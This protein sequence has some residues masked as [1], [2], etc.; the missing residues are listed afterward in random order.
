MLISAVSLFHQAVALFED[1]CKAQQAWKQF[2]HMCY[3]ELMWCFTYKRAWRM[4]YFYAD[5]L[6]QESRW[7]KVSDTGPGFYESKKQ[8]LSEK[9]QEFL[10]SPPRGHVHVHE[11]CV[12][13]YAA[14]GWSPAV[15]RGRGGP[16]QVD[17]HAVVSNQS[18]SSNRFW[19][20]RSVSVFHLENCRNTVLCV[21]RGVL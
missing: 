19:T 12:P 11:S 5:L 16:F 9:N 21:L 15:W 13:Q 17:E 10:F 14:S 1:G 2:H 7:S 4:A 3:W 18:V 6:S 8:N 20:S